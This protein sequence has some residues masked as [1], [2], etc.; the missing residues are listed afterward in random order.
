M[1]EFSAHSEVT[2]TSHGSVEHITIGLAIT[3]IGL[4]V[5][6]G[7]PDRHVLVKIE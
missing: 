6:G 1:I 5:S 4:A 7:L 2:N 3:V